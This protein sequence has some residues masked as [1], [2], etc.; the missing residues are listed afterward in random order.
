MD[1][2]LLYARNR[3][4]HLIDSAFGVAPSVERLDRRSFLRFL[5]LTGVLVML[6]CARRPDTILTPQIG[7]DGKVFFYPQLTAGFWQALTGFYGGFPFLAQRL[8]AVL[9]SLVPIVR[10]PLAYAASTL[11]ITASMA[12]T[13]SLPGFRHLV[14]SDALRVA[15]CV[16]V[17]CIPASESLGLMPSAIAPHRLAVTRIW[18][19]SSRSWSARSRV[20]AGRVA[21]GYLQAEH[22]VHRSPGVRLYRCTWARNGSRFPWRCVSS[23]RCSERS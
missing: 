8:V 13:F 17:V 5:L 11:L 4:V 15:V 16:G 10:V 9:G 14:R 18:C 20:G 21:D 1:R 6:I 12:A 2:V 22:R 3:L 19:C 7:G 23:G